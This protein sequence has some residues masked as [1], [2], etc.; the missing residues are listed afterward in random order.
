MR[1]YEEVC[2][3]AVADGGLSV[4]GRGGRLEVLVQL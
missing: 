2:V 1:F 3:V 4:R